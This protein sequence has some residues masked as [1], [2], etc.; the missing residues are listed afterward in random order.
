MTCMYP[1]RYIISVAQRQ[2]CAQLLV[3]W[4][5]YL[6]SSFS[7][8]YPP[9]HPQTQC[10]SATALYAA[11]GRGVWLL[12]PP[13]LLRSERGGIPTL[14]RSPTTPSS[15]VTPR[16]VIH[17][18]F[19][20]YVIHVS[21]SSYDMHVSS[22]SYD[23]WHHVLDSAASAPRCGNISEAQCAPLEKGGGGG[24]EGGEGGEGEGGGGSKL[25]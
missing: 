24:G 7:P 13:W 23:T 17:V 21:S 11:F 16:C 20:S 2:R 15:C 18:S 5:C 14:R 1:P 10:G 8:M 22:S 12:R 9:P 3:A 19:S 25:F 4:C 6:V